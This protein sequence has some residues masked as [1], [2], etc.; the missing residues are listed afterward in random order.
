M[1]VSVNSQELLEKESELPVPFGTFISPFLGMIACEA[2]VPAGL[3]GLQ[4]CIAL[5]N[6]I[7][8]INWGQPGTKM[9]SAIIDFTASSATFVRATEEMGARFKEEYGHFIETP[10]IYEIG[11]DEK[12]T[13]WQD[14][15]DEVIDK[16]LVTF[17]YLHGMPGFFGSDFQ[18][19]LLN[20]KRT[21]F[22]ANACLLLDH[23]TESSVYDRTDR[24]VLRKVLSPSV[25][26]RDHED[27]IALMDWIWYTAP[28]SQETAS[29]VSGTIDA[30]KGAMIYANKVVRKDKTI[31]GKD[32][33]GAEKGLFYL[34]RE[35]GSPLIPAKLSS[36]PA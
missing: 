32:M 36:I 3:F 7:P 17:I 6:D 19:E 33:K 5:E 13:I 25:I 30:P 8:F 1:L 24:E 35:S 29:F 16:G 26:R 18:K 12:E 14:V 10:A 28:V 9:R 23:V 27:A 11:N 21:A 4:L 34:Y 20:A 2:G 22:S 31:R 15:K